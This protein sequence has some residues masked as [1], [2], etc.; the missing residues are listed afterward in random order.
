MSCYCDKYDLPKQAEGCPCDQL[1]HPQPLR[2]PA[3]MA[4]IPRQ[5]ALF[6]DFRRAMLAEVRKHSSLAN[7]RARETDDLGVMLLEMWAYICDNL[8]FYDEVIAR[9]AYLRT[10]Q[11]R[12][13]LRRL[14]ALLGYLPRPAIAA[15]VSL[16]ASATGRKTVSLPAGTAFRSGAFNGEAPQI[17]ELQEEAR[18]HPLT[19]KWDIEAP[20]EGIIP[21]TNPASLLIEP[22]AE[23]TE[24][25]FLFIRHL[26]DSSL[27]QSA[28]VSRVERITGSDEYLYTKVTF[29]DALNL[30]AGTL[31]TDLKLH[32]PVQTA[33]FWTTGSPP[34]AITPSLSSSSENTTVLLDRL[35][36]DIHAGNYI[37]ISRDD[38]S[39]WFRLANVKQIMRSPN[40]DNTITVNGN[41]FELAAVKI[42]VSQ[43]VLDTS[44]ND[45][46]RKSSDPDNWDDSMG[47]KLII[48]YGMRGAGQVVDEAK[49]KITAS[50]DLFFSSPV[51]QPADDFS[52]RTFLLQD[53]N[54][55]AIKLDGQVDFNEKKLKQNQGQEPA[56]EYPLTIPVKAFGN[57]IKATRGESVSGEILGSGDAS[58]SNQTFKLRK[59]PLTYLH[60]PTAENDQGVAS[61]LQV[62]VDGVRW[63]EAPSFFGQ[64]AD[65]QI[66]IVR[67]DDEGE[68]FVTFGDGI[69]GQRLPTGND[70]VA[71]EYR[72]GAGEASPPEGAVTQ[73]DKPMEGLQSVHNPLPASGGADAE[74]AEEMRLYAPKSILTLGRAVS[75]QDLEAIALSVPGVRVAQASWHWDGTRQRAVAKIWFIGETGIGVTVKQRLRNVSDPSTPVN[76]SAA[77]AKKVDLSIDVSIDP[78]YMPDQVL[79]EIRQVLIGES[80][81]LLRPENLHIGRPLFRS[82]IFEEVLTVPGAVAVRSISW[83]NKVF[84]QFGKDPGAGRYFDFEQGILSING[85]TV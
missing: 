30:P 46:G 47:D 80:D 5:I 20:R 12:P 83:N 48:H 74:S 32:L 58:V 85:K 61:T 57:V 40:P 10:S 79:A 36:Q 69:R 54:L 19:N 68:S 50:D 35:Y 81:S 34:N 23:I 16:A 65:R 8:S 75:I 84:D 37:L 52:S 78:R 38:Q 21:E 31:L 18:I 26:S 33:K 73:I 55:R 42:P 76:V 17:F 11:R 1:V 15:S 67:Q 13:S 24:D 22:D 72:F 39:R 4:Q 28:I 64:S 51:E 6:G 49:T 82:Q 53:K 3:G 66:Y 25:A 2:I 41:T 60:S 70:N 45:S 71:A 62:Y 29:R 63:G 7:W 43:L 27:N 56:W 44:I 9:E 14:V 77:Q 59:K